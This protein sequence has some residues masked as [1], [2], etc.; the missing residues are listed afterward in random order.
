M[1]SGDAVA[2][3][4]GMGLADVSTR[5]FCKLTNGEVGAEGL[6][7]ITVLDIPTDPNFLPSSMVHESTGRV[8][9]AAEINRPHLYYVE[10]ISFR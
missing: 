5:V 9:D 10:V 4:S 2:C 1:D 6:Q 3:A 7:L 8:H